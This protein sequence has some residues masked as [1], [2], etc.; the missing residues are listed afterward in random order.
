[1]SDRHAISLRA[2][3]PQY[4]GSIRRLLVVALYV[5]LVPGVAGAE[6]SPVS[7]V[8]SADGVGLKGYDPVA[9]FT[10]GKPTPGMDAYTLRWKGI[11]YRFAS[12][13][14]RERFT[15]APEQYAPQYGGYCAYAMSINRIADIDPAR[16]TIVDG[17]LYLNNNLLS[18]TLWSVSTQGK[19]VSAD[20]HW[21]VFPKTAA[22]E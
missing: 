21:A 6:T 19:I 15:A 7:P 9:Y 8:N 22:T 4:L 12:A 2:R 20:Q 14:N 17:K 1:M 5:S 16:W 11:T 18:Q 3:R 10:A 13:E